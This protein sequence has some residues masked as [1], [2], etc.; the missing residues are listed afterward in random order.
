V[1]WIAKGNTGGER[2]VAA[3]M[4]PCANVRLAAARVDTIR[5]PNTCCPGAATLSRVAA[6][7]ASKLWAL[8]SYLE[9]TRAFQR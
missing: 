7:S 9:S 1:Q 3:Q 5:L 2:R 8:N 4:K 6:M